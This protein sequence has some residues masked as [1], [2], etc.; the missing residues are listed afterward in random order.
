M[1]DVFV[2]FGSYRK[3]G[4]LED[5]KTGYGRRGLARKGGLVMKKTSHKV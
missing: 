4:G 1:V 2:P 5:G 3:N